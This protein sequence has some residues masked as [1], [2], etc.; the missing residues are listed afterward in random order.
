MTQVDDKPSID[1]A[2]AHYG[3]MGMQWGKSS[4]A[5]GNGTDIRRARRAVGTAKDAYKDQAKVVSATAKGSA[6]RAKGEKELAKTKAAM[7][8]NPDRVMAARL[9]K[10]EKVATWLLTGGTIGL[11]AIAVTSVRSR[12]IEYKQKSNKY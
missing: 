4:R 3:V 2:L 12:R 7:L 6:A 11:G 8:K 10:G 5:Q 9:S 1:E